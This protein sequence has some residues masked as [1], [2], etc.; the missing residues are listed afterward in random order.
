M[1]PG[2]NAWM[3]KCICAHSSRCACKNKGL[4][5][6]RSEQ[7]ERFPAALCP[8]EA[9]VEPQLLSSAG[10]DRLSLFLACFK[11]A[12]SC[13][14]PIKHS[15]SVSQENSCC[16][17]AVGFGCCSF[18]FQFEGMF[19][20]ILVKKLI[21]WRS[22]LWKKIWLESL[23]ISHI[24]CLSPGDVPKTVQSLLKLNSPLT[25]GITYLQINHDGFKANS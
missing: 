18:A 21:F 9:A 13:F 5:Q 1:C 15:R 14:L 16:T 24:L 25:L 11:L 2:G 8:C 17:A 3:R 19:S 10:F 23:V 20:P 22:F 12:F 6:G 7:L 4:V